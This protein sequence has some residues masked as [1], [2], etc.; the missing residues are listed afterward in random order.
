MVEHWLGS[1]NFIGG[2][3]IRGAIKECT[4]VG[5]TVV[6]IAIIAIAILGGTMVG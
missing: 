4:T 5:G 2:A 6:G 3:V 1:S